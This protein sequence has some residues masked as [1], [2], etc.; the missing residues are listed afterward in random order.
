MTDQLH[1]S[2][3]FTAPQLDPD[4]Q[5]GAQ[6]VVLGRRLLRELH[7]QLEVAGTR[8]HGLGFKTRVYLGEHPRPA[9]GGKHLG[10]VLFPRVHQIQED[11]DHQ[12]YT[13]AFEL[14]TAAGKDPEETAA[15]ITRWLVQADPRHEG[16]APDVA[17]P[18]C[19]HQD[20]TR[21]LIAAALFAAL[22]VVQGE[23]VSEELRGILV[24]QHEDARAVM[25]RG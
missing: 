10:L 14:Q 5:A 19:E 11:D 12:L 16:L 20:D 2:A 7:E 23:P 4:D 25:D 21:E 6:N 18:S 1:V 3:Q 9:E 8:L 17:C 13:V 15:T 24:R 22:E